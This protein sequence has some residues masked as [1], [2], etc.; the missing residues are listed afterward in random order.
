MAYELNALIGVGSPPPGSVALPQGAWL[1]PVL[2]DDFVP[3]AFPVPVAHV[4]AEFFGGAGAQTAVLYLD[5]R[6][7][8][9]FETGY[10]AINAALHA[11]G[12]TAEPPND[13]FDTLGLGRYRHTEDWLCDLTPQPPSS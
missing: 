3:P 12:I 11:L 13:A 10:H 9:K 1:L 2:T 5:G 6:P 4:T 7:H 8:T